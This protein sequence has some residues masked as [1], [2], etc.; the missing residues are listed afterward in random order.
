[1]KKEDIEFVAKYLDDYESKLFFAL[2]ESEQKHS[3]RVAKLAIETV[4]INIEY[5]EV[6]L[7]RVIRSALLH[8]IGKC[9]GKIN[10]FE[11]SIMVIADKV[12]KDKIKK[13][14][15]IELVNSYYNHGNMSY[16]LLKGHS[17]D[18]KLLFLIKNHHSNIDSDKELNLLKYCDDKN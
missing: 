7:E 2:K 8:D 4:K 18:E 10:I 14:G 15:S 17:N 9:V 1:M 3:V 6:N 13:F 16:D 12:L 5:S 11:K